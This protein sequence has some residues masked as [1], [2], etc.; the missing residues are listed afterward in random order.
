MHIYKNEV[1]RFM[2][3]ISV[4][5]LPIPVFGGIVGIDTRQLNKVGIESA[6][7]LACYIG[8]AGLE[9]VSG[10]SFDNPLGT[11]CHW[12]IFSSR[13]VVEVERG[14]EAHQFAVFAL[15]QFLIALNRIICGGQS[16]FINGIVE[17]GPIEHCLVPA[18]LHTEAKWRMERGVKGKTEDSVT[19]CEGDVVQ[20]WLEHCGEILRE[21]FHPEI[22]TA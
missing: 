13:L 6:V 1:I 12:P 18:T 4:F 9:S 3:F 2:V 20:Y 7:L 22:G 19:G 5:F 10:T 14:K 15:T 21:C 11:V 17:L 16:M 8:K